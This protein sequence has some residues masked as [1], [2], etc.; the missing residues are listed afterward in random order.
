MSPRTQPSAAVAIGRRAVD[1]RESS[2]I[3]ELVELC[4]TS[5][6]PEVRGIAAL[7]LG[8][9]DWDER[10]V[11]ALTRLLAD[12]AKV[13]LAEHPEFTETMNGFK[14][15][16]GKII[17]LG[18]AT[19]TFATQNVGDLSAPIEKI[20]RVAL[21]ERAAGWNKGYWDVVDPEALLDLLITDDLPLEPDLSD[22]ADRE[23]E[24]FMWR[25]RAA[26]RLLSYK[27][28]VRR[29]H[30]P[31]LV[32]LAAEWRKLDPE[33]ASAKT[34]LQE[35][36]DLWTAEVV[37]APIDAD[38]K[39]VRE[40]VARWL[41]RLAK[42]GDGSTRIYLEKLTQDSARS[43]AKLAAKGVKALDKAARKG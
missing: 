11:A 4:R 26:K 18:M 38:D 19:A 43:V 30:I 21:G 2:A 40:D 25:N 32:G 9:I 10:P 36:T 7:F 27:D 34:L 23:K 39:R 6:C 28:H 15:Y 37:A 29:E 8:A 20:A 14:M 42:R 5:H 41:T 17:G 24:A 22:S 35:R 1:D 13:S 16:D 3:D 12:P 31:A 33:S